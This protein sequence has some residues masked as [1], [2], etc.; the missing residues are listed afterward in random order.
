LDPEENRGAQLTYFG[1]LNRIHVD[2]KIAAL[3][4]EGKPPETATDLRAGN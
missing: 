1:T 2:S 3:P 4:L